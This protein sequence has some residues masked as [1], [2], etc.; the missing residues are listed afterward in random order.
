VDHVA[1]RRAEA[2]RIGVFRVAA[3]PFPDF[4]KTDDIGVEFTDG[5][6]DSIE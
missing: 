1:V 6:R 4:L 5:S 2:N 3:R